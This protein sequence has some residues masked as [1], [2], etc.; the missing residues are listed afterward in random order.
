[1][2]KVGSGGLPTE[3]RRPHTVSIET[4]EHGLAYPS[5]GICTTN[6]VEH[7]TRGQQQS[8]RA[9]CIPRRRSSRLSMV[10]LPISPDNQRRV[11]RPYLSRPPRR[12][13]ESCSRRTRR[14]DRYQYAAGANLSKASARAEVGQGQ[15][16]LLSIRRRARPRQT[17]EV[18]LASGRAART[19]VTCTGK[20]AN[21]ADFARWDGR[22]LP[23]TSPWCK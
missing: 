11:P 12:R 16:A 23:K 2:S 5:S 14:R 15:S 6:M 22:F 8:E 21:G 9:E 4:G 13:E 19:A 3:I 7:Q 20:A 1:M 17:D 18:A 10:L